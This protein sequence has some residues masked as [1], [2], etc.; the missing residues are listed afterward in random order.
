MIDI[1]K[2]YS[3][4]NCVWFC[5]SLYLKYLNH[6]LNHSAFDEA[7]VAIYL[8]YTSTYDD[9]IFQNIKIVYTDLYPFNYKVVEKIFPNAEIKKV[10]ESS[11]ILRRDISGNGHTVRDNVS[12]IIHCHYSYADYDTPEN[13]TELV[14]LID[15]NN[16][17]QFKN[18]KWLYIDIMGNET[19][20][21]DNIEELNVLYNDMPHESLT[22]KC[23]KLKKINIYY[24]PLIH[25][26]ATMNIYTE[27]DISISKNNDKLICN[28]TNSKSAI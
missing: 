19:I 28:I 24:K 27:N 22:V 21:H 12:S 10:S 18:L 2:K 6:D 20:E 3:I 5:D 25:V 13:I 15:I 9:D 17:Q 11:T 16:I 1:F 23:P 26:E 14:E 8:D 4:Y 7:E